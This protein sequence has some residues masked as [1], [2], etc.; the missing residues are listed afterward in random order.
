M[1]SGYVSFFTAQKIL[2]SK[3]ET[4][5]INRIS[6]DSFRWRRKKEK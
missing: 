5:Y 1:L 3:T 2:Y 4:R 6:A